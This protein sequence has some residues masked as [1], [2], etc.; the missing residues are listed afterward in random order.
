[1]LLV[2]LFVHLF[3]SLF[4][5][6]MSKFEQCQ[7]LCLYVC[8]CTMVLLYCCRKNAPWVTV[9]NPYAKTRGESDLFRAF[10]LWE[11]LKRSTLNVTAERVKGNEYACVCVCVTGGWMRLWAPTLRMVQLLGYGLPAG[12]DCLYS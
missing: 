12:F 11:D 4:F 9:S 7:F 3:S 10:Q 5:F 2:M 1:M 6:I 8:Q